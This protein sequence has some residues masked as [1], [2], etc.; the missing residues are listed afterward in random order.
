MS[1]GNHPEM[2]LPAPEKCAA[3]TCRGAG[4]YPQAKPVLL[5]FRSRCYLM[6]RFAKGMGLIQ[7]PCQEPKKMKVP[8]IY[9]AYVREYFE[10]PIDYLGN[11][12][13]ISWG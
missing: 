6:V 13:G 8:T 9:K 1:Q 3:L 4:W 12:M 10:I 2:E 7:W 11:I 5:R